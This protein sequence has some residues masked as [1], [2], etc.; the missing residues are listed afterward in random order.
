MKEKFEWTKECKEA[1]QDLNTFIE[2]LLVLT[3]LEKGIPLYLYLSVTNKEMSSVL[4]QERYNTEKHYTLS[5]K[6]SKAQI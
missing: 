4:V 3:H 1:F 2:T 6:C 5:V